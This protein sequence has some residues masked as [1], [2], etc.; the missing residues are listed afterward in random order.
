MIDK[1]IEELRAEPLGRLLE[2]AWEIRTKNFPP[3]L[4]IA[5]PSPKTYITDHYSNRPN[6]FVNISITGTSCSLNCEHCKGQLLGSMLPAKTSSKLKEL[7][8]KLIKKGC[9]GV[10]ISGGSD[11]TGH[12]PLNDHFEGIKYLK[13]MGLKVI[14]HTGL[15]EEETAKML[16]AAGVD[17]VLLDVIGSRETIEKVYHLDAGPDAFK[18]SLQVLKEHGLAIAPHIVIGLHFGKIMGE[19]DALRLV[20]ES[21][22]DVIVLVIISSALSTGMEDVEP[23]APDEIARLGAVARILNPKTKITFGCA[24]PPQTRKKTEELIIKAGVNTITYPLD[25]TIDLAHSLGL[26]TDFKEVCCSLV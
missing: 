5:A 26:R 15:V 23:P 3:I 7:G 10:L 24:S 9:S 18:R 19:Y 2:Y 25:E 13:D 12:V 17:Q 22:P 8:D 14:V 4:N 11:H 6:R 16:K 1:R 20:T 21:E